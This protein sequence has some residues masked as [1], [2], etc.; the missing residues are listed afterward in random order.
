MLLSSAYFCIFHSSC[1]AIVFIQIW[2]VIAFAN[3][4]CFELNDVGQWKLE[5]YITVGRKGEAWHTIIPNIHG[6]SFNG[7]TIESWKVEKYELQNTKLVLIKVLAKI[8]GPK[9]GELKKTR[10]LYMMRNFIILL[11]DGV[12]ID[13]VGLVIWFI[14]LFDT[15][16]DYTLQFTITYTL[17]F[18]ITS[19]LLL[20]GNGFQWRA[21]CFGFLNCPW[22]Q[23][24][25]SSSYSSQQLNH[26]S[27]RT[28]CN[29]Q[30]VLV[31]TYRHGLHKKLLFHY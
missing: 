13:R 31:I 24:P 11:C 27:S 19:S 2:I 5:G 21:L 8:F 9:R 3:S 30:L 6:T 26:S 1:L 17:A 7:C 23:L 4:G 20:V 10:K 25:A 14:G 29:C 16:C 15:A 28:N 18:A 12:T 22:P